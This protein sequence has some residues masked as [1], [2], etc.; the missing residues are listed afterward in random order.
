[1]IDILP[2]GVIVWPGTGVQDNLA[3]N[4]K[5]LGI[6]VNRFEMGGA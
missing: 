4:A 5:K 6:P 3:D 1:M 2:I